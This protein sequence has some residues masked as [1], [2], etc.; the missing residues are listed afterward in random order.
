MSGAVQG[1]SRAMW[2]LRVLAVAPSLRI[3]TASPLLACASSLLRPPPRLPLIL[4]PAA[5]D[6]HAPGALALARIALPHMTRLSEHTSPVGCEGLGH[7]PC[8]P[9]PSLLLRCALTRTLATACGRF[10]DVSWTCV[11]VCVCVCVRQSAM[12][13]TMCPRRGQV[14]CAN[15]LTRLARTHTRAHT[16]THTHTHTNA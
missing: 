12:R 4:S 7:A 16:H 10:L 2:G 6:I 3:I 9:T 13:P 15:N 14:L 5:A 1:G 11:C 8:L